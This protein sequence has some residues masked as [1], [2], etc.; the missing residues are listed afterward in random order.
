MVDNTYLETELKNN[1]VH[2]TKTDNQIIADVDG[3]NFILE[4]INKDDESVLKIYWVE[5]EP[6]DRTIDVELL[7]NTPDNYNNAIDFL[8]SFFNLPDEGV[9]GATNE[10]LEEEIP[11]L[12]FNAKIFNVI[13][14]EIN[15]VNND[16]E[17]DLTS[18]E[19]EDSVKG[20]DSY[21]VPMTKQ[22]IMDAIDKALADNNKEDY[23]KYQ[24]MLKE[25][26]SFKYLKRFNDF[27]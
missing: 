17:E 12:L 10:L 7:I 13:K 15:G 9:I 2:Y 8:I 1:G 3:S 11:D 21:E 23:Y 24:S 27:L 18:G 5:R 22:Q 19:I 16:I 14:F 6:S 25:N 20:I 4:I 26:N